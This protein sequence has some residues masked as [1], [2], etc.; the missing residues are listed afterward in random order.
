V[1]LHHA[2]EMLWALIVTQLEQTL[3]ICLDALLTYIIS[4]VFITYE[5]LTYEQVFRM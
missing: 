1:E 3:F 2:L 5:H 4:C